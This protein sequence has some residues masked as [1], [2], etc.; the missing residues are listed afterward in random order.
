MVN[1]SPKPA[2]RYFS[3][4]GASQA[5]R[6]DFPQDFWIS[7]AIRHKLIRSDMISN[8]IRKQLTSNSAGR[9]NP[10]KWIAANCDLQRCMITVLYKQLKKGL[11]SQ[12]WNKEVF[13]CLLLIL[14]FVL[15]KRNISADNLHFSYLNRCRPPRS[16]TQDHTHRTWRDRAFSVAVPSLWTALPKHFRDCADLTTFNS[17]TKKHLVKSITPVSFLGF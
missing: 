13:S 10:C 4:A 2:G 7:F 9:G 14:W 8:T 5:E 15:W 17:L 12:H 6:N 11:N 1:F 16:T 3:T